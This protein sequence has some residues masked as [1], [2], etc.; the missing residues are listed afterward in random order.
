M[1]LDATSGDKSPSLTRAL[2]LLSFLEN[3]GIVISLYI[4]HNQK[5][6]VV[7]S[8]QSHF[9]GL[10]HLRTQC[11]HWKKATSQCGCTLE[12]QETEHNWKRKSSFTL[13]CHTEAPILILLCSSKKL[14]PPVLSLLIICNPL[15]LSVLVWTWANHKT[16][17]KGLRFTVQSTRGNCLERSVTHT[18]F[19]FKQLFNLLS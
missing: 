12:L 3:L 7:T 9:K 15:V 17:A 16:R 6:T 8:P 2:L 5:G 10:F 14:L 19:D 1:H 18:V 4:N 11:N 13:R